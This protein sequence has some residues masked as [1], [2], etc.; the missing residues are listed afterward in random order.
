MQFGKGFGIDQSGSSIGFGLNSNTSSSLSSSSS[1]LSSGVYQTS[2]PELSRL[3]KTLLT[4]KDSLTRLKALDELYLLIQ[5]ISNKSGNNDVINLGPQDIVPVW[6]SIFSRLVSSVN[7]SGGGNDSVDKRVRESV[8]KIH[9]LVVNLFP[10][11]VWRSKQFSLVIGDWF[12]CSLD[13]DK[14]ANGNRD[15]S[16]LNAYNSLCFLA[17]TV[18][19]KQSPTT[20]NNSSQH[21]NHDL[22]ALIL[23]ELDSIMEM[24]LSNLN[25]TED[26]IRRKGNYSEN[27]VFERIFRMRCVGLAGL[28][29]LLLLCSNDENEDT[30]LMT[31]TDSNVSASMKNDDNDEISILKGYQQTINKYF[32]DSLQKQ[33]LWKY[34]SVEI[35]ENWNNPPQV[36][37]CACDL[38]ISMIQ[39]KPKFVHD[40]LSQYGNKIFAKILPVP[41]A[42]GMSVVDI[43]NSQISWDALLL[44]IHKY[45]DIWDHID[46]SKALLPEVWK[47]LKFASDNNVVDQSLKNILPLFSMLPNNQ[48]NLIKNFFC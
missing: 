11:A 23:P 47:H 27:E 24:L 36:R 48:E 19:I 22:R 26:Q 20:K 17:V 1:L 37:S 31:I 39:F 15:P 21:N 2:N 29:K 40:S 32:S 5:S 25:L 42:N 28:S 44:L 9:N 7:N 43:S 18:R 14:G 6:L 3:S 13:I 34:L 10:L 16:S 38:L 33:S 45:P 46:I 8:F 12:A 30:K 35:K 41:T 4:K